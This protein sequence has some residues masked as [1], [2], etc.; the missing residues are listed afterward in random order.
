MGQ[1]SFNNLEFGLSE[2]W[3]N[4]GLALLAGQQPLTQEEQQRI[5]RVSR[6]QEHRAVMVGRVWHPELSIR[7]VRAP[8][9]VE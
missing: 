5:E 4:K 1:Q 9:S 7:N 3:Y 8:M 6:Q 2:Q